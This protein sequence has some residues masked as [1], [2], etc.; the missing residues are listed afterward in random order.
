[1]ADEAIAKAVHEIVSYNPAPKPSRPVDE[2]ESTQYRDDLNDSD[3]IQSAIHLTSLPG[4]VCSKEPNAAPPTETVTFTHSSPVSDTVPAAYP[5]DQQTFP[6]LTLIPPL[7]E[8]EESPGGGFAFEKAQ[9]PC[10]NLSWPRAPAAAIKKS[11]QITDADGT[12]NMDSSLCLTTVNPSATSQPQKLDPD[13]DPDPDPG[14]TAQ[15]DQKSSLQILGHEPPQVSGRNILE[16]ESA[17]ISELG[18]SKTP[19]PL[20]TPHHL[21]VTRYSKTTPNTV[22]DISEKTQQSSRAPSQAESLLDVENHLDEDVSILEGATLLNGSPASHSGSQASSGTSS[23]SSSQSRSARTTRGVSGNRPT[24]HG[25]I[26]R[27]TISRLELANK[28]Q[29]R[30]SGPGSRSPAIQEHQRVPSSMILPEEQLLKAMTIRYQHQKNERDQLRAKSRAKDQQIQDLKGISKYLA[31]LLTQSEQRIA[32]QEAELLKQRQLVPRWQD[33]VKQLS[34]FVKGLSNDHTRLRDEAQSMHMEQQK[35]LA[36]KDSLDRFFQGTVE[37]IQQERAQHR[38]CLSKAHNQSKIIGQELEARSQDLLGESQKLRAEQDRNANLQDS[39]TR[40]AFNNQGILVKLADQEAAIASKIEVLGK[41][42]SDS[43]NNALSTGQEDLGTGLQECLTVLKKLP[44]EHSVGTDNLHKLNISIEENADRIAHL[45]SVCQD[46]INATS[47]YE[48]RLMSEFSTRWEE[49]VSSVGARCSIDQQLQDLQKTSGTISERLKA[50]EES[51]A[52][53]RN[54]VIA[55]ETQEK[56]QLHRAA[57]FEAEVNALRS[58]P[59]ENPLIA[60]RLHDSEKECANMNGQLSAYQLQLEDANNHLQAKCQEYT[61]LQSSHEAVKAELVKMQE[62]YNVTSLEK[63]ALEGQAVLNE[64]RVRAEFSAICRD[65][66]SRNNDKALNQVHALKAAKSTAEERAK[67]AEASVNELTQ[68]LATSR[69]KESQSER[70]AEVIQL[71][72]TK[73]DRRIQDLQTEL[74]KLQKS[75]EEESQITQ[76]LRSRLS[77]AEAEKTELQKRHETSEGLLASAIQDLKMQDG[78]IKELSEQRTNTKPVT[79]KKAVDFNVSALKERPIVED[80]QESHIVVDDSQDKQPRPFQ[81]LFGPF[82]SEEIHT[83]NT[84]MSMPE[85]VEDIGAEPPFPP[86]DAQSSPTPVTDGRIMFPPSPSITGSKRSRGIEDSQA[87]GVPSQE[88]RSSRESPSRGTIQASSKTITKTM[89]KSIL[90]TSQSI[91]GGA[92]PSNA[93]RLLPGAEVKRANNQASQQ[94]R[95]ILKDNSSRRTSQGS[96]SQTDI[97]EQNKRRKLSSEPMKNGL[98]PMQNSPANLTGTSRRKTTLR[99]S[100]QSDKYQDRFMQELEKDR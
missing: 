67:I 58:R 15:S 77:K 18:R 70:D 59:Q 43:V 68:L 74:E 55:A 63:T 86:A 99:R 4:L 9:K 76:E 26:G 42:I 60:L 61:V 50:T 49:L 90:R 33:R 82:S 19:V 41:T 12:A 23:P 62:K 40:L 45:A 94:S 75:R 6:P 69:N 88:I 54:R 30:R 65:E 51:L 57:S 11:Q 13:P 27:S 35:L 36:D 14:Q 29:K 98:G 73:K 91:T 97:S 10:F 95:G 37:A 32:N 5:M 96:Q 84:L 38:D 25:A 81:Q 83:G 66:I 34:S 79:H 78:R 93:K 92:P 20:D 17:A 2:S 72:Q 80:S 56:V 53:S 85:V 1:M 100:Q 47:H 28:V 7:R 89:E 46:S 31:D 21:L 44:V 39:L 24:S 8:A 52:E 71:E 64:D 16:A 3:L 22:A 87:A 48:N